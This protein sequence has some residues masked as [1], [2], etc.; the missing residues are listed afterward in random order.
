MYRKSCPEGGIFY[1]TGPLACA[2]GL[3]VSGFATLFGATPFSAIL[4]LMA[5]FRGQ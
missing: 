2:K 5:S 1:F 4:Y 3:A